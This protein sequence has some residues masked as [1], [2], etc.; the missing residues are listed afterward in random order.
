MTK[1]KLNG[2]I[3]FGGQ[4]EAN[5]LID[6]I[7]ECMG[8]PTPDGITISWANPNCMANGYFPTATTENWYVI[9]KEE[10]MDCLTQEQKDSIIPSLPV[11]WYA[12]GTPIPSPSGSTENI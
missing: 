7:N 2:W 5:V 8:F 6:Q 12:C 3:E 4:D 10:I 1:S 11:D 9:I